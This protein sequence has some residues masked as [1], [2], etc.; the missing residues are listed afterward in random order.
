[1]RSKNVTI[2]GRDIVLRERKIKDIKEN[3]IPK[4]GTAWNEVSK[5]D[6]TGLVDRLGEQI[7][8]IFPELQGIDVEECYPS[9]LE[10]FVEAWI[11]VNFT[12]VKRLLGP[13]MSL[14]KL[15]QDKLG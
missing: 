1:M 5:G 10:G 12:G 15:G 2:A 11:D 4:L 7:V 14:A 8:E 3:L 13:L 9:E 6:I